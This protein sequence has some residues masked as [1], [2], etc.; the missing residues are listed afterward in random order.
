M[1]FEAVL[2]RVETIDVKYL[3]WDYRQDAK[4]VLNLSIR[5]FKREKMLFSYG[6]K[7]SLGLP[8]ALGSSTAL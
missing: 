2:H 7:R 8:M 4:P 5:G 6:G 3:S 1:T